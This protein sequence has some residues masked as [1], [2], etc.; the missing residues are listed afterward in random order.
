MS[1]DGHMFEKTPPPADDNHSVF[2]GGKPFWTFGMKDI[3]TNLYSAN[4]GRD[5]APAMCHAAA[6]L[7]LSRRGGDLEMC[8]AYD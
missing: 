1:F 5:E 2:D 3:A 4:I 7:V 8:N 6:S